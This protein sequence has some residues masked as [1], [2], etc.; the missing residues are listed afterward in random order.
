MIG[1]RSSGKERTG[2]TQFSTKVA[3]MCTVLIDVLEPGA[4][5]PESHYFIPLFNKI[6][7]LCRQQPGGDEASNEGSNSGPTG[8]DFPDNPNRVIC[9][10]RKTRHQNPEFDHT[11]CE[12]QKTLHKSTLAFN[13]R[14]NSKNHQ[15]LWQTEFYHIFPFSWAH[16]LPLHIFSLLLHVG[17]L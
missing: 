7:W 11:Q 3:A 15:L 16:P 12:I 9:K 14:W 8:H 10:V 13:T 5:T 17:Q 2:Q 6:S 4:F 1:W